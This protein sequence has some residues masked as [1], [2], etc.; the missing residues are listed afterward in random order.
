MPSAAPNA[1]AFDPA[2]DELWASAPGVTGGAVVQ[3]A[4]RSFG[5]TWSTPATIATIHSVG[6]VSVQNL[7]IALS[8]NNHAA[9]VWS[10][11]GGV[12]IALRSATGAWQAPTGL[13][14]AG[15]ASGLV[16]K[17]DAQGNG[18]AAWARQTSSGSVVEAATWTAAGVFGPVVQLSPA[19]EG[20]FLPDLAVNENGTAMVVWQVAP[21]QDAGSPDQVESST[22]AAGGSWGAATKVSPVVPQ[23]WTPHVALDSA[24]NATA[25]WEQGSTANNYRIYAA[26]RLAGSTWAGPMRI[27]PQDWYVAGQASVGADAVGNVTAS[28]VVEDSSGAMRVHAATR[29]AGGAWEAPVNLG[30]LALTGGGSNLTP[31]VAVARDGSIAVVGWASYGGTGN[32]NTAVRLG[33][34]QWVPMV[35]AGNPGITD[36]SV[37]NNARASVVWSKNNGVKYHVSLLE[38]DFR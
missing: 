38:S 35:V 33:S 4:S 15:G 37:T 10:V 18:V 22:R 3:V 14:P 13:T 19:A 31:P 2:G 25:V 21:P 8:A 5:G 30:Q 28:W 11:G 26:T 27:E 6:V 16:A 34:G 24:G 29:P 32:P 17:L 9:A 23:T 12:Q 36:V 1:F 20:A 7:S